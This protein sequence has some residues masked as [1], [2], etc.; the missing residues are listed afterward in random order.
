MT[1]NWQVDQVSAFQTATEEH[2]HRRLHTEEV[3]A[4]NWVEMNKQQRR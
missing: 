3:T 2:L 1:N 4:T